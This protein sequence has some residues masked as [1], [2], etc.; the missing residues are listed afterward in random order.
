MA[1]NT[2]TE[3][4]RPLPGAAR[5]YPE[6]DILPYVVSEELLTRLRENL[7]ESYEEREARLV[8]DYELGREQ[9]R[10]LVRTPQA[11]SSY[12]EERAP[13]ISFATSGFAS[14]LLTVATDVTNNRVKFEDV[15]WLVDAVDEKKIS[16]DAAPE[17]IQELRSG[18]SI[19][20]ALD[21]KSGGGEVDL[22]A[23][24]DKIIVEKADFIMEKGAFAQKPIMGLV[25]KEARGR[26][27]GKRVNE[28]VKKKIEEFLSKLDA[29]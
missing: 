6:T 29:L 15:Q 10:Q 7:P 14:L 12:F 20:Q 21:S 11:I 23:L 16:I 1:R 4:M 22:D 24:A 27:D 9:A 2:K 26:V 28:V 19:A 17:I 13:S 25:M 3:Y 5:M 8:N 18:K